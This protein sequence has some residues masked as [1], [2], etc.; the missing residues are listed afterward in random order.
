MAKSRTLQ[1][2]LEEQVGELPRLLATRLM[3]KKLEP[4]GC[5][6]DDALVGRFVDHLLE[7]GGD[8]MVE[9]GNEFDGVLPEDAVL[10]FDDADL[11][12]LERVV[13]E[14]REDLPDLMAG[15]ARAASS[16]MLRRYK[17]KWAEWRPHALAEMDRFKGNLEGRWGKA[18][19]LL[20]MFIE[21]SRDQ[22]CAFHRRASR[23]RSARR[24][25]LDAAL[26]HLH[27][28]AIQIS[29]EIMTLMEGGFADG[30]MARWRTLHEVT[31]VAMVLDEG[32]DGLAERYLAHE[33]VEAR[34]GLLQFRECHEALGYAPFS[35]R[36]ARRIERGYDAVI[37][38]FGREF[39][40]DYGW[41]AAH[42]GVARPTFSQIEGA[43]GR[44]MM[45]SHYRLASHN[46]HAGAKGIAYR[47]GAFERQH[48]A[49]AGASNVGF[50]EPGQNLALS[51]LHFTMLLLPRGWTL[52]KLALLSALIELQGEIGPALARAERAI[53]RDERR[54][55]R[56]ASGRAA[57]RGGGR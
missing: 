11:A 38:R 53:S 44:A 43:A 32:G 13:A 30:A 23:R 57:L 4:F 49:I 14:F 42:L 18:F 56:E 20:R 28:R 22:G 6:K 1:A 15:S 46:V 3:R 17:K 48:A 16:T 51:L 5:A 50:V 34:K 54:I 47:L 27:A 2:M 41:V 31:C 7:G 37:A 55:R 21:L 40:G 10:K 26:S 45:R 9:L 35:G 12:E 8:G 19:D 36:E 24:A 33:F 25:H 39:G 52:D 29:S